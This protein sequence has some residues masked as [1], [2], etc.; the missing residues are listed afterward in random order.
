MLMFP[1]MGYGAD[2]YTPA[3]APEQVR[4]LLLETT[5]NFFTD[6]EIDAWVQ[7]GTENISARAL[8]IQ[9][10]DTIA[11]VT[12]QYEYT[13]FVSG[14]AAAA[15][16]VVKV[17]GCFYVS[18]D[19]EYI[20]LKRINP[21]QIADLPYMIAGPPKYYYHYA[22]TIG[23]LPLPTATENTNV[24]RIY[25]AQQSQ[26]V[27]DLPNEYQPLTFWFAASQACERQGMKDKASAFYGKYIEGLNALKQELNNLP[28]EVPK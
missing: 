7:E 6:T 12:S 19:N 10:S 1:A 14:G 4:M 27:G 13:A 28:A 11:L 20:G 8:C 17:W 25:Y 23:I 22:D 21:N 5:N 15:T 18:P 9:A 24:V 2:Y 3:T 26:T 16:D